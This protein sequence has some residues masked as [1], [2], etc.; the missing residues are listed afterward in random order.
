[1]LRDL[2]GELTILKYCCI[3]LFVKSFI[4]F[5][6]SVVQNT[7]SNKVQKYLDML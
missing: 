3:S 2:E 5:S 4:Y 1:M 6:Q 7:V